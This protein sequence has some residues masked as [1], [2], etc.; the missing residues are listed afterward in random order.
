MDNHILS[1]NYRLAALG[2]SILKPKFGITP[3]STVIEC[4]ITCSAILGC[5]TYSFLPPVKWNRCQLSAENS[6][7]SNDG[8]GTGIWYRRIKVTFR[9]SDE[10]V[11]FFL[12]S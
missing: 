5:F 3:S 10:P 1:D 6:H 9:S 2:Q 8:N 11:F 12:F 4:A 7:C